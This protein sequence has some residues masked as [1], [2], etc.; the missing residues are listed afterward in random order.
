MQQHAL[1]HGDVSRGNP[2]ATI[3]RKK[4]C[5]GV[6]A[7]PLSQYTL[8]IWQD[9]ENKK[10]APIFIENIYRTCEIYRAY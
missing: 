10:F 3:R 6:P 8:R 9:I 1:E 4:I 2:G 7:N 5:G